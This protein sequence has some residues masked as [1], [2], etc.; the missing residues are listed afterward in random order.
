MTLSTQ[1]YKNMII[2]AVKDGK[3]TPRKATKLYSS[4]ENFQKGRDAVEQNDDSDVMFRLED[5]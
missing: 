1:A 5:I 3:I 2:K 4:A